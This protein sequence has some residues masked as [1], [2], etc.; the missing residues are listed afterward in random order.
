MK[1]YR[2]VRNNYNILSKSISGA[3]NRTLQTF[4]VTNY[5]PTKTQVNRE[6]KEGQI[7]YD[8]SNV[9]DENSSAI[10]TITPV[11]QNFNP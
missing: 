2:Y 1:M 8:L 5:R 11:T 10:N 9:R 4:Y 7:I 6:I 3:N